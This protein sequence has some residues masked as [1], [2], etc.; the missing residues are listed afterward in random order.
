MRTNSDFRATGPVR[1]GYSE[2]EAIKVLGPPPPAFS[3][4]WDAICQIKSQFERFDIDLSDKVAIQKWLTM[5]RNT[6]LSQG[7]LTIDAELLNV[8]ATYRPKD[9]VFEWAEK[10]SIFHL[11]EVY[12]TQPSKFDKADVIIDEETDH[13]KYSCPVA[14]SIFSRTPLFWL[15]P[16]IDQK[17]KMKTVLLL[18]FNES[19]KGWAYNKVYKT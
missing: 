4:W 15:N 2:A 5:S 7:F 14:G 12:S 19:T 16:V 3:C 1:V 9:P 8:F 18:N 13:R 11:D 10:S 6:T 17:P